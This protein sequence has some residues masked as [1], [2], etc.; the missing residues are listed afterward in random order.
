MIPGISSLASYPLDTIA[1]SDPVTGKDLFVG[2]DLGGTKILAGVF[3][4][5]LSLLG[6]YK[7]STKPQRGVEGVVERMARCI[8]DAVDECDFDISQVKAIGVGAPGAVDAEKGTVLFAPNLAWKDVPLVQ[9]LRRHI[10]IP[11][12]LENDCTLCMTG[13]YQV[14]LNSK[15]RSVVGVFVG[16]G[17]GGGIIING[18]LYRG[19][20]RCAG[21]IGHM[22]LDVDGPKCG[23]GNRGCLEALASR[24]ALFRRIRQ[25]VKEGQ[26]TVLTDMLGKD[27][28]D[29]RSGDLRK[30]I[31]R[32]D[33]FVQG[34]VQEASE[35]LGIAVANLAHILGPEII[36]LGGGVVEALSEEMLP[37]IQRSAREHAMPGALKGVSIL[38]SRLADY[39]GVTGGAV[40]AQSYHATKG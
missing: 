15:P 6:T 3:D 22:I 39:A 10:K 34:V 7:M 37:V 16:T 19:A 29:M 20:T 28:D 1:M 26:A 38:A 36:I 40:L 13:V 9:L 12:V 21:E 5:S 30:A 18:E 8:E 23:C 2:V 27:L 4:T 32:G 33:K 25:A 17:V 24:G 35:F 14:E 31:R 11:V